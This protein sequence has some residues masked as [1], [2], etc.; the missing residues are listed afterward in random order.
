MKNSAS[1]KT[2]FVAIGRNEGERLK[3]CLASVCATGAPAV[4]VDSGSTDGSQDFARS[5]G[6]EVLTLDTSVPFTMARARNEGW[7]LLLKKWPSTEWVHF[8]DGDC[9]LA[10]GW[11]ANASAFLLANPPVAAVCGRRRERFPERSVF[12]R[13]CE[14]EWNTPIGETKSCGGDSLMRRSALEEVGGFNESLIAGEEP[15]MCLRLRETGWKIWRIDHDMTFHDAAILHWNQWWRRNLRGGYGA[16]DVAARTQNRK[17]ILFGNQVTSA[18]RW[19]PSF[20]AGI[21]L[22]A[23]LSIAGIWLP[24]ALFPAA[25][26]GISTVAVFFLQALRI[27]RG[28]RSRAGGFRP[29]IEYGFLTVLAK[30]PQ[31]LGILKYHSDKKK[32]LQAKLIEYKQ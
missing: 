27:A 6:V 1:D 23:L 15:E 9:S 4:Y 31:Y 30:F 11:V 17:E 10:E 12:N 25:V 32:N 24:F 19:V 8:V 2:G 13:L 28:A 26:F 16:A 21:S 7:K 22:C 14:T 29:A 5:L 3:Q 18:L 20:S